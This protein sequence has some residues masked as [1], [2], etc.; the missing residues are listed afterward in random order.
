VNPDTPPN[1]RASLAI[2][3]AL[4]RE[5]ALLS[6]DL[7]AVPV[8][9]GNGTIVEA[10]S[11]EGGGSQVLLVTAGMGAAR[12]SLAVAAAL[13]HGPVHTILSVGLAGACNPHLSPGSVV[14]ATVV[15]DSRSGE[16]FATHAHLAHSTGGVL[17]TADRI[18]GVA[19]KRR[20]HLSYG[21]DVVDMEAATVARLALAHGLP[22]RAI[23]SISDEHD[24]DLTA[25]AAFAD[26]QGQFR[27]GAFAL[28]TLL[29]PARWPA[30]ATLGR[31][32]KRAL[33]TLTAA[34]HQIIVQH[35]ED[36]V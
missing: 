13:A 36:R 19:E 1:P 25:L 18:A 33:E 29:R 5:L 30:A 21:A 2:I 6:R 35:S 11:L 3:A 12:A 10:G 16:R 26:V 32:S 22:F 31:N 17:V 15:I 4:P 7:H 14:E 8:S 24:V 9:R 27:T 23:K 28:H 34:I 20:L